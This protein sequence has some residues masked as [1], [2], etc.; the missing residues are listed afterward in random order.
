MTNFSRRTLDLPTL[1]R[2]AIGFDRIFDELNRTF[3]NSKNDGN[4]P[5]YNVIN[6]PEDKF[7]IEVAVAGFEENELDVEVRENILTIKGTK[8]TDKDVNL[9]YLH[10]GISDR[11][12][13]RTFTLNSDIH[14]KGA[15]VKNG[16][17]AIAL[18][19]IVPEEQK[20]K[21][22]AIAFQK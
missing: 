14:V 13:T 18:E 17:L 16:I 4:Y 8:T 11:N 1:H 6:L 2:H 15:T 19:L 20:P 10:K 12:F 22:I 7:I 21:K 3:A 9:D 5:P